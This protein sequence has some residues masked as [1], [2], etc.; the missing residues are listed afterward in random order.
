M[1]PK[2]N[3]QIK[4]IE[5]R[6][7]HGPE[8]GVM[9][10]AKAMS[11]AGENGMDLIEIAP[12]A[13]PPVCV[14]QELGKWKYDQAKK[15]KASKQVVLETKTIQL[16]PVTDTGD[17]Q[18]KARHANDFLREGHRVQVVMKFLGRELAK[19]EIGLATMNFF[20]ALLNE[21][22]LDG[23][24]SRLEGRQMTCSLVKRK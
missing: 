7:T 11:V 23:V 1:K 21:G 5:V 13:N 22:Q 15:E 20:V 6:V 12:N 2:L 3:H 17:L 19:P 24:I 18:V 4:A 16:R 9:S 10:H 8:T 14:I